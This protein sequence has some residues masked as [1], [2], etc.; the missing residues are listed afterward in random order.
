M[1]VTPPHPFG[2]AD[3]VVINPDG[4]RGMLS[5]GFS[6]VLE[7]PSLPGDGAL[8]KLTASPEIVAPGRE[9][10]L[11]W[12]GPRPTHTDWVGLFKVGDPN[13]AQVW[14]N[15]ANN[16]NKFTIPAPASS[17]EYEFRYLPNEGI[18]DIA[19]SNPVKVVVPSANR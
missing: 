2:F 10:T 9:L 4:H 5:R 18:V 3:V 7:D 13:T 19:R 15:W 1:I 8:Y 14:A 12:N 16:S 6:F 11:T 17:G